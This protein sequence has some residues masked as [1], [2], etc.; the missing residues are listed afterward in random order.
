MAPNREHLKEFVN[1]LCKLQGRIL[2]KIW[3]PSFFLREQA[4]SVEPL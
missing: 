2:K 4:D 1:S 3:P